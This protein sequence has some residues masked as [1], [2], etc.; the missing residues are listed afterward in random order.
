MLQLLS[1]LNRLP[2]GTIQAWEQPRVA[3]AAAVS[4]QEWTIK[5]GRSKAKRKT[6]VECRQFVSPANRP[7]I[8][9]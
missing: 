4:D 1:E 9:K 8:V 5:T 6:F 2:P 3:I 7:A